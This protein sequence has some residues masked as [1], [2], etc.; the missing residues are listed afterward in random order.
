[1]GSK[2]EQLYQLSISIKDQGMNAC[3]SR[4]GCS[5]EGFFFFSLSSL[6][7]RL[8]ETLLNLEFETGRYKSLLIRLSRSI[9]A[10]HNAEPSNK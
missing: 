1:M 4:W 7:S 8:F 5:R 9:A 10:L 3:C 6:L 2:Y